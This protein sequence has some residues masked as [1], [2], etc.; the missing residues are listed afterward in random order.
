MTDV[1]TN[2]RDVEAPDVGVVELDEVD[3]QLI[4]QLVDRARAR[5]A[6][7]DR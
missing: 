4:G 7:A 2:E 3:E 6:A 5:G 1:I